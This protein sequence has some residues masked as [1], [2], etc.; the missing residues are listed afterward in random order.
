MLIKQQK[1]NK[2]IVVRMN[3][4]KKMYIEQREM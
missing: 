4:N 2:S 3:E 1:Q